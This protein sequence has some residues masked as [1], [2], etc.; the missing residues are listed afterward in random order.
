MVERF[1]PEL[2]SNLTTSIGIFA[3]AFSHFLKKQ[4]R[5]EQDNRC[6]NCGKKTKL[7]IH[8]RVPQ[9]MGGN[10]NRE[11][12]VGLCGDCHREA[13]EKALEEGIIYPGIKIN[14]APVFLFKRQ[15]K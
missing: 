11:N 15:K 14:Q 10:D 7:Q 2:V 3:L 4:V 9:S 13:D 1:H 12:A 6:D 5:L 8:H